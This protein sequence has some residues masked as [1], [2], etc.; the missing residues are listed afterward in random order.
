MS[1]RPGIW[2]T[3]RRARVFICAYITRRYVWVYAPENVVSE[4]APALSLA[5]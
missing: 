1:T 3:I 5:P 4:S 2:L